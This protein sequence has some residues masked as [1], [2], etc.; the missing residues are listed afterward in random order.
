M[1][2]EHFTLSKVEYAM[3]MS[4]F[5]TAYTLMQIPGG[6]LSE[7]YGIRIV[8][9]ATLLFWS[10]F[11]LLTPLAAGFSSLLLIRFFFGLGE[12]P[13]FPNNG[14][15]LTKWFNAKEKAFSGSVMLSG[16]FIGP[17]VGP[18]LTVWILDN[19][20][21]QSVFFL[22]GW[23]GMLIAPLWYSLSRERPEEHPLVNKEEYEQIWQG[24]APVSIA[25]SQKRKTTTAPWRVFLRCPRF[26][27]FGVQYFMVNYILYTFLTWI[28]MYLLE[29][30]GLSLNEMGY[31]ASYPWLAACATLLISGKIS[32]R[33]IAEGKS[34]FVARAVPAMSG[35]AGC[36]ASLFS[37]ASASSPAEAVV[38]LSV[39]FGSLGF[40]WST[41]WATCQDLGR[42]HAASVV[43]WMQTWASLAGVC[44]PVVIALLVE[45]YN[46][47]TTMTINALQL[48]VGFLCWFVV[49]P[50]APLVSEQ[51]ASA[52]VPVEQP[53]D[54]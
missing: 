34:R 38:W 44:A 10:V 4:A 35:L 16:A 45:R 14:A 2:M 12:G 46:W 13:L 6:L 42:E 1:I 52:L 47:E 37:T 15:F 22:F 36:S 17:A 8:G 51:S 7:R 3:T 33:L 26:W 29:A 41:S 19:W 54:V 9:T 20:G 28:P 27:A 40:S 31:A 5:V 21:W 49:R 24:R 32:D 11:T 23:V 30:R 25:A 50:D 43:A 18:P 48:V 53:A 39:A